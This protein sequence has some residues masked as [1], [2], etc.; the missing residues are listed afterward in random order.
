MA[1]TT[2]ASALASSLRNVTTATSEAAYRSS[3]PEHAVGKG[4]NIVER[5]VDGSSSSMQFDA[6]GQI[7][8]TGKAQKAESATASAVDL[9]A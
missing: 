1:D 5:N 8:P 6:S 2:A 7:I 9:F 3:R 4:V